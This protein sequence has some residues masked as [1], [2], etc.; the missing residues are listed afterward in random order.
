MRR[1][2]LGFS[3]LDNSPADRNGNCLRAVVSAQLLHDVFDV[4]LDGLLRDEESLRD[5][6]IAIPASDM[7]EDLNLT[8]G[9]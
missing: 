9:Q 2:G 7:P 5:V 6:A 4:N 3:E 1:S 8:L